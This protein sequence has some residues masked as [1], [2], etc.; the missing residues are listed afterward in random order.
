MSINLNHRHIQYNP[1][2]PSLVDA[3]DDVCVMVERLTSVLALVQSELT[4]GDRSINDSALFLCACTAEN[5]AL[6]IKALLSHLV[7]HQDEKAK[8]K[9]QNAKKPS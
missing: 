6:D 3:F 8:A 4:S 9:A 5:E 1:N 7:D 2:D